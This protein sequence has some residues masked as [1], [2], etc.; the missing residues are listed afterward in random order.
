[1]ATLH[2]RSVPDELHE[3]LQRL[4]I[5]KNR[6]LSAQVMTLLYRGLEEEE[7][8]SRQ[9]KLLTAIRRRR[10][11]LPARSRDSVALLREDR[12]R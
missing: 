8:R 11:K 9:G 6:S 5:A 4:A 10:F 3:R 7:T 1:M 2:I 12:G